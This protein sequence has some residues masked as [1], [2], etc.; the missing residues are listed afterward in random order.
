LGFIKNLVYNAYE[1]RSLKEQ[2][3]QS[4]G[5][6]IKEAR[7]MS[8][9][10]KQYMGAMDGLKNALGRVEFQKR[11][12]ECNLLTGSQAPAFGALNSIQELQRNSLSGNSELEG[13]DQQSR[14]REYQAW[15][16]R[17][18]ESR[19]QAIQLM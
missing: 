19:L 8:R 3:I 5:G 9:E 12:S 4:K 2:R 13:E 16:T 17:T 11:A 15:T 10:I 6:V 1:P 18:V 14:K 7:T